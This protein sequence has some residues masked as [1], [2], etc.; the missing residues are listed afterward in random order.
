MSSRGSSAH[1]A[2]IFIRLR[3]YFVCVCVFFHLSIHWVWLPYTTLKLVWRGT[4]KLCEEDNNNKKN[5]V[6]LLHM[7]SLLVTV[8]RHHIIFNGFS[9]YACSP[10]RSDIVH[11]ERQMNPSF[12]S[13]YCVRIERRMNHFHISMCLLWYIFIWTARMASTEKNQK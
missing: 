8:R 4:L 12:W 3:D 2:P 13:T 6:D 11:L 9:H 10:F 1:I 7:S 5:H